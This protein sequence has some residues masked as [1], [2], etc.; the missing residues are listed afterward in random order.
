MDKI[1]DIKLAKV[2]AK[3]IKYT[4]QLILYRQ[5]CASLRKQSS[6]RIKMHKTI[7]QSEENPLIN[8]KRDNPTSDCAIELADGCI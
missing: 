5:A 7:E 4:Y 3:K 6:M 1:L 2:V 8:K